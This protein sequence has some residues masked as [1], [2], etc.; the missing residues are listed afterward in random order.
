MMPLIYMTKTVYCPVETTVPMPRYS[1]SANLRVEMLVIRADH[2]P[3][4]Y[5]EC[6]CP[7]VKRIRNRKAQN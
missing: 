1:M 7:E 2:R 5:G 6:P 3:I 4:D